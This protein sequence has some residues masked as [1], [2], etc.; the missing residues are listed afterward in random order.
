MSNIITD[1][2]SSQ[3]FNREILGGKGLYLL[4]LQSHAKTS[5]LYQVPKFFIIPTS[6]DKV[7]DEIINAYEQLTKPVAVR[8]SSPLEDGINAS[9]AGLF[10][11]FLNISTPEA[12]Q[13]A[14]Q[15]V[16]NSANSG[17]V[18]R[19]A[20]RMGV[21]FDPRMAV[22]V[23]EQIVNPWLK[24]T[25]Q[26][27]DEN[28][29]DASFR[30]EFTDREGKPDNYD[31]KF[32]W[33]EDFGNPTHQP[34]ANPEFI[35]EGDYWVLAHTARTARKDLGLE[36]VV[37]VEACF[38]P[39]K[40]ISFV[41]IRTLPTVR[42]YAAELDMDVPGGTPYVESTVCNDV[43]GELALPAYVT[44]SQSGLKRI[45]IETGQADML[46][47]GSS[48]DERAEAF[49]EHSK[50]ADNRDFQRFKDLMPLER[51]EGLEQVLPRYN[52]AW[53]KGNALFDDY[54]LVCDKLDETIS[55]MAD[56]TSNK[57]AIITCLESKKTSHAMTVARDLGIMCM[58]VDGDLY[59][60][61]DFF[62]QVET[63]DVL[64]MK[65]DGKR[66]V[67]YIEKKRVADPYVK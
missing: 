56:A 37:Q 65:S 21:D 29:W 24:G 4:R 17:F 6:V 14:Y 47:M 30:C 45:L 20:Q 59:E 43:A 41:Q 26:L 3:D 40:P 36:G 31:L 18:Q 50:L 67:A 58:G 60:M 10:D 34:R 51:F 35:S 54:I 9:F 63:G 49:Y 12:F 13:E 15:N 2:N 44:T 1:G 61:N 27:D 62:N 32:E 48:G 39:D 28:D 11:S 66:A 23:Q 19:Y 8:S 33:M 46:M 7:S 52:E 57:R 55:E 42:S 25:I 5:G 64:R 16:L 38:S 22:I 53:H